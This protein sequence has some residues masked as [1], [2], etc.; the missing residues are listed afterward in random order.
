MPAF[1]DLQHPNFVPEAVKN[2]LIEQGAMVPLLVPLSCG[3][4][5]MLE[6]Y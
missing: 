2:D 4:R 5:W 1:Q 3:S 6:G